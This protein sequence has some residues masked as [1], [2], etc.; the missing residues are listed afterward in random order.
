V[1]GSWPLYAAG[2]TTA[3]GAHGIAA[4]LG[5]DASGHVLPLLTLGVLLALYDGAE[6]VLKPVF[7]ALADRVGPRRVL[8]GGLAAFA[9][10]SAAAA[11]TGTANTSALAAWPKAPRPR[12]SPPPHQ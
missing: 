1:A 9:V 10:A 12:R 5:A 7:G 2:F 4:S 3:F 6:I 8:L 11:G